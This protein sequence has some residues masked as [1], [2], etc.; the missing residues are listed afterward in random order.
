VAE[1]LVTFIVLG[2]GLLLVFGLPLLSLIRNTRALRTIDALAREVDGLRQQVQAMRAEL[3]R[4]TPQPAARVEPVVDAAGPVVRPA[5]GEPAPGLAGHEDEPAAVPPP[6]VPPFPPA[7]PGPPPPAA[8]P[9]HAAVPQPRSLEQR[10]GS[11][12]L[13]Y[14][15][16]A[17]LL[18]GTSYFIK[19]AFDNAWVTPSMRVVLGGIAGAGLVAAGRRFAARGLAFFGQ[20]LAGGGLGILYLSVYSAYALYDLTGPTLAFVQL[21]V[22]SGLAAWVADRHRSQALALVAVIGGFVSPFL[23]STGRDA[24]I[25]LFTYDAALVA[26]TM[27]LARRHGWPVLNLV[28]F[29]LTGVTLAAWGTTYYTPAK[30]VVTQLFLTLFCGMFLYVLRETWRQSSALARVAGVVLASGP[31]LYHFASLAILFPHP[32]WLLVYLIAMSAG[33]VAMAGHWERPWLRAAVFTL[34]ALP[35][36]AWIERHSGRSWLLPGSIAI[37]AIYGVHLMATLRAA[38]TGGARLPAAEVLLL[39][40]NAGWLCA[41]L[42]VLYAS[43]ALVWLG[44]LAA[45]LA[46]WNF[47]LAVALRPRGT[48]AWVHQVA[49]AFALAAV[50][51]ALEFDGPWVTVGWAAE[52]VVLARLGLGTQRPWLR[53]A[54]VLLLAVACVRLAAALLEPG[55]A[56]AWPIVNARTGAA[57]FVVVLLYALAAVHRRYTDDTS[58]GRRLQIERAALLLSAHALTLLLAS[59]EIKAIFATRAWEGADT[60]GAGAATTAELARHVALSTVWAAYAVVLVAAGIR[61]RYA[62]IR[63]FAIAVLA[64]AIAKVFLIDLARLDR[65][66]RILS[67]IGLGLLLLAASYLYQRF[68][69]SDAAEG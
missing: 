67:V 37:V 13:L 3:A 38:M 15:A 53:G 1:V 23:V 52:G 56:G 16:L 8:D 63:Y 49:A 61:R 19:Y 12:W 27:Y 43:H 35:V 54:G 62:P 4:E 25:A 32:L 65:I 11:R 36:F 26:G 42:A 40:A 33:G 10:I 55:A 51:V 59:A 45:G 31:V 20:M 68:M 17:S 6:A 29:L 46:V 21:V 69:A 9:A 24:Q 34:V 44:P 58:A 64:L 22:V 39:H 2:A 57:I 5:E 48:E 18:L 7:P 50:A 30:W 60:R 66:W 41:A 47:G 28:S 14:V